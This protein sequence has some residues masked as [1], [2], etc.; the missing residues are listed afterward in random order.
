MRD[1]VISF[2]GGRTSALMSKY[3]I[4][5]DKFKD[6]NKHFIFANTGKEREETLDFVNKV[7]KEFNLKLHWIEVTFPEE[8][9]IWHKRVTYETASR[10]GEPFEAGIA[11][12]GV[13]NKT[14]PWCTR[15]LKQQPIKKYIRHELGL[16]DYDM[17]IG[18][19]AD[20]AHRINWANAVA[21]NYIYPLVTSMPIDS[22]YVRK[23]WQ[24]M[25]FD[26]E[27]KDY[28]GNCDLCWKKS[29]RKLMTILK[30][31]P[32][33]ADWWSQMEEGYQEGEFQFY[34]GELSAKDLLFKSTTEKYREA[35]DYF[36]EEGKQSCLFDSLDSGAPCLCFN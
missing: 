33:I 11:R 17:A 16:K 19:R 23:F 6:Y 14:R 35:K 9:K 25:P 7:D 28:E 3:I 34:R 8:G 29:Q 1:L 12:Y 20:E 5:S 26:L 32:S 18:I 30:H 13:P 36:E 2:S 4:E 31:N 24:A 10:N 21:N 22:A 15:S 27:L